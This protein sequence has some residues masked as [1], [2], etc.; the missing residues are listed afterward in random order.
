LE[1]LQLWLHEDVLRRVLR[2][3]GMLGA[4]KAVGAVPHLISLVLAARLLG[5][6]A[7]GLVIVLRSY[8]QAAGELAKFQSWQPLIRFG[9]GRVELDDRSGFRDLAALAIVADLITGLIAAAVAILLAP[10]LGGWFG[11]TPDSI[12]LAQIYCLA[13]PLMTSATPTG[14]LRIFDRFDRLAWQS[15]AVPTIRLAGLGA[16]A[17]AGAPFWSVVAA[18]LL[19]DIIGHLLLWWLAWVELKRR[20]FAGGASPSPKRALAD[21]RGIIRFSVASNAAA[22]LCHA[23]A[24]M[25][26]LFVGALLGP[27][28][29][30]L[31]RLTQVVLDAALTPGELAMRSLFPELARLLQ[32]DE[33]HFWSL[34]GRALALCVG[35]AI[36][37]ALAVV[38]AAPY[39]VALGTGATDENAGPLLQFLALSMLPG[40]AALPIETALLALGLAGRLFI[41]RT[42]S[43]VV[44]FGAA[45]LLGG[46][47]GL[48][49]IGVAVLLGACVAF[50]G[51]L[52]AIADGRKAY[53]VLQTS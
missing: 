18:W 46:R 31:Y 5:L 9:A 30:G 50:C 7:F 47:L 4:G 43:V 51:L 20:G 12:R 52:F 27:A 41:V 25:F 45:G 39:I 3:T 29:A 16:A 8:A 44:T 23:T 28:A 1:L 37:L 42:L 53:P 35:C 17:L 49:G 15:I 11:L 40:L 48:S 24:P 38:L 34:V 33:S 19:S 13:I 22:T 2:N 14:I 6:T 36:L 21:N 10:M 26:T 32:R